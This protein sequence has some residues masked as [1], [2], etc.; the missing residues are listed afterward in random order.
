M[1]PNDARKLTKVLCGALVLVT[2]ATL[3]ATYLLWQQWMRAE[4]VFGKETA[5]SDI[6]PHSGNTF[7]VTI[8]PDGCPF[9]L[10]EDGEALGPRVT[11]DD[12]IAQG[13]GRY[14]IAAGRLIFS[15][16]DNSDPRSNGRRY[17]LAQAIMSQPLYVW[18][19]ALVALALMM[20]SCILVFR[21]QCAT[22]IAGIRPIPAA[23]LVFVGSLIVRL[24]YYL[25]ALQG[26]VTSAADFAIASVPYSD[27]CSWDTLAEDLA[28]GRGLGNHCWS[29]RRPFY[30]MFLACFYTWTGASYQL[31][32]LL[33]LVAGALALAFV[34]LFI[35]KVFGNHL[36]ALFTVL[37]LAFDAEML[38][39]GVVTMSETLGLLLFVWALYEL[40]KGLETGRG[41]T[42]FL[43]G[44]LLGLSNLTRTLT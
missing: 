39:S 1:V 24:A 41:L 4:V 20:S 14:A 21:L 15:T 13:N 43:S 37:Y 42:C 30:A 33:N 2:A 9:E 40:V 27:A 35:Q 31:A 44:M 5:L 12:V 23:M 25:I 19:A 28:Q 36:T 11:V 34:Y 16:S 8:E 17:G 22:T 10:R 7:S 38:A 26:P 6:R 18:L 3:V 32:I 29:A